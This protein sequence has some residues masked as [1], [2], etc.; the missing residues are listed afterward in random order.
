[1]LHAEIIQL[2]SKVEYVTSPTSGWIQT[3]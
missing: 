3:Y 1:M 2:E